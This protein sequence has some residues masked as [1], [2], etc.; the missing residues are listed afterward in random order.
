LTLVLNTQ[1]EWAFVE[2]IRSR[3]ISC[4]AV[5]RVYSARIEGVNPKL[6]A[7]VQLCSDRAIAE[8]WAAD[9]ALARNELEGPFTASI[10]IKS[11]PY[12]IS[13]SDQ[14]RRELLQQS[15]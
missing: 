11:R 7:V 14:G 9:Q 6:N 13:S 1:F 5:V 2:A 4:D 10:E 8:A 3:K 12:S 15:D